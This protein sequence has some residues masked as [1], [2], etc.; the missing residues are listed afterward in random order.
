VTI[1]IRAPSLGANPAQR[2]RWSLG[3][4]FS[5]MAAVVVAGITL[6]PILYVVV[7]GFRTEAAIN[8]TPVAW[9]HPWIF[10]NYT[11]ILSSSSFW[12]YV[13][14]SLFIAVVATGLSVGLGSLPSFALA[15]YTFK[16]REAFFGLFM[17]GLLF[18]AGVASL[19]LYLWLRKFGLLET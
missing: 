9:P 15:R 4:P 6:V 18:P 14:N 19:P 12:H 16:G 3:T 2:R 11:T 5:Y 1:P 8:T 13:G 7:S 10:S 17:V